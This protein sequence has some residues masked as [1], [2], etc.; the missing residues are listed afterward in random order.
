MARLQKLLWKTFN[1]IPFKKGD[2]KRKKKEMLTI[3]EKY[4]FNGHTKY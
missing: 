1:Q 2:N 3:K 4:Y